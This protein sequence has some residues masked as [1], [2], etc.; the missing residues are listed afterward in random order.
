MVDQCLPVVIRRL[1]RLLIVLVIIAGVSVSDNYAGHRH[2][3]DVGLILLCQ[4]AFFI[5][6]IALTFYAEHTRA[7]RRQPKR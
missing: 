1:A 6:L 5:V 7:S 4:S 3:S 2:Q